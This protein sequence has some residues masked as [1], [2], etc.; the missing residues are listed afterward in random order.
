[1]NLNPTNLLTTCDRHMIFRGP[2]DVVPSGVINSGSGIAGDLSVDEASYSFA[3]AAGNAGGGE[4]GGPAVA[5]ATVEKTQATALPQAETSLGLIESN[6]ALLDSE[7]IPHS[8]QKA[9]PESSSYQPASRKVLPI[10]QNELEIEST[11]AR[12]S[13]LCELVNQMRRPYCPINGIVV[14]VPFSATQNE[15]LAN[16]AGMLV[17]QD[18][19]AIRDSLMVEA[20]RIAVICD[21]Q[22]INGCTDLIGRFPQQQKHRRLGIKFPLVPPCDQA[23]VSE[24]IVEGLE[25][26][27]FRMIPPL[28]N[29]LF[30][31]DNNDNLA[32]VSDG[33]RRIYQFSQLLRGR[34]KQLERLIRRAFMCQTGSNGRLRGCYLSATGTESQLEQGFTAG[35][36][37]QVLE[38][39]N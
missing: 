24:M 4:F 27:C 1:M 22:Q 7:T 21:I 20:P 33:N 14:L 13:F 25:W 32:I 30:L 37:S 5:T 38:M 19:Q 9:E 31:T 18:L 17:E 8:Q 36:F 2:S 11:I 16:H 10:L 34:Q 3:G 12:L 15:T 39:Q 28:V 29:R 23:R 35:I 6:I 26:M